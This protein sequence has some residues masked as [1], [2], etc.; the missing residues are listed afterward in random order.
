MMLKVTEAKMGPEWEHELSGAGE[1]IEMKLLFL[2][3]SHQPR[4]NVFVSS[5]Q[6]P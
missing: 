6:Y 4:V 3:M 5:Y 2:K 1:N